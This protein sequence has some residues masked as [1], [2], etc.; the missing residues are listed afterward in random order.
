MVLTAAGL[1]SA[2][3]HARHYSP[4]NSYDRNSIEES[5]NGWRPRGTRRAVEPPKRNG[6]VY[7]AGVLV[8]RRTEKYEPNAHT[9]NGELFDK[10]GLTAAHRSLPMGTRLL[11]S[12]RGRTCVVR[13]NDRGPALWTGRSL[14]VSRGAATKLGLIESGTGHVQVTVLAGR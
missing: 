5:D 12:H 1:L 9:A 3:A 14:D 11:L 2:P 10:W 6:V 4:D 7:G 8:W 13:I